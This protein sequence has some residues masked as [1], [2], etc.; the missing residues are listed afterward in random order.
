MLRR[1]ATPALRTATISRSFGARTKQKKMVP[2]TQKLANTNTNSTERQGPKMMQ[3]HEPDDEDFGR[4]V[5]VTSGKGG[6]GKTTSAAS[7]AMVSGEERGRVRGGGL[8][9]C[10]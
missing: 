2:K 8:K 5:A 3:L 10:Q 9:S 6:V 1:L 7:F 4:I